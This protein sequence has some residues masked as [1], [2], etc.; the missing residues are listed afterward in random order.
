MAGAV[1]AALPVVLLFLFLQRGFL[2]SLS[3]LSGLK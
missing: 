1:V 2:E 3:G